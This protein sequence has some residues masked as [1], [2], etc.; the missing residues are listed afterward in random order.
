MIFM[1]GRGHREN[2]RARALRS[3]ISFQSWISWMARA[4]MQ[5][6]LTGYSIKASSL[7]L[8]R[9][10]GHFSHAES[11]VEPQTPF[12]LAGYHHVYCLAQFGN[13]LPSSLSFNCLQPAE[14]YYSLHP[15]HYE[16]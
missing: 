2:R 15:H 5:F 3:I 16:F 11:T 14:T 7:S 4:R 8:L 1:A 13:I 12:F 9:S 6:S 10:R